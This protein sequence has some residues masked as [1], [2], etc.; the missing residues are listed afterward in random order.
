ME[1]KE[2]C[3]L[4]LAFYAED[5]KAT[6]LSEI[7]DLGEKWLFYPEES[8]EDF[9]RFSITIRKDDGKMEPFHLPNKENFALL[10]QAKPVE[11]PKLD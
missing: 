11:I 1:L 4:A 6:A 5:R 3:K 10:K 9:G 2:A 7:K 8:D